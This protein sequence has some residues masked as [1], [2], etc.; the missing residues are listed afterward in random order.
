MGRN[1][2][3]HRSGRLGPRDIERAPHLAVNENNAVQLTRRRS[4]QYSQAVNETHIA[5]M[6]GV[7]AA[8]WK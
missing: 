8:G 2:L 3:P 6:Q 1:V 4:S 7:Y 5:V